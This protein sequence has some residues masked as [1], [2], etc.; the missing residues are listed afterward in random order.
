MKNFDKFLTPNQAKQL[1]EMLKDDFDNLDVEINV[2]NIIFN[3]NE[4]LSV[5]P[6][7]IEFKNYSE[8][9]LKYSEGMDML[10]KN[11][12]FEK[13]QITNFFLE[14]DLNY[15]KYLIKKI[16][17]S[18]LF[19]SIFDKFSNVSTVDDFYFKEEDNI[20]D[21][22]NRIIFLSFK[23]RNI[24][25]YA[26]TDLLEKRINLITVLTLLN[27]DIYSKNLSSK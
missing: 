21:Y 22:I 14:E 2:E 11:I 27:P 6:L 26:I 9:I 12:L 13:F 19:K 5:S 17:S 10:W 4:D 16:L 24:E 25:K 1:V 8:K 18:N 3:E 7:K 15:L 23:A 20:D